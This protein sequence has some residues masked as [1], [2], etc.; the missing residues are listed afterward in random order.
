MFEAKIPLPEV[1]D[2]ADL[3]G[4]PAWSSRTIGR[5]PACESPKEP[6]VYCDLPAPQARMEM[7]LRSGLACGQLAG[8][9]RT[10]PVTDRRVECGHVKRCGNRISPALWLAVQTRFPPA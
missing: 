6:C 7:R 8:P 5:L 10:A 9:R 2:D 1:K 3:G 4:A